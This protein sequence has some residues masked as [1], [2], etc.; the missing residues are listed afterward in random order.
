MNALL[1][2][3]LPMLFGLL[4]KSTLLLLA[5]AVA[6]LLLRRASAAVRH[7]V[8]TAALGG[9]LLLPILSLSLPRWHVAWGR[10][11]A[12]PISAVSAPSAGVTPAGADEVNS[13]SPMPVPTQA[14]D[15]V[16]TPS[17]PALAT[18][19]TRPYSVPDLCALALLAIWLAGF[20]L[21]LG[22]FF[23]GMRRIGRIQKRTVALDGATLAAAEDARQRL[24]VRP[25]AFLRATE[26]I[27]AVPITWGVFR[28]VVLLP[29]SSASWSGECLRAA[30]LHELAHVQ[31]GDWAT[32]VAARFACAL[33]WW[34]PLA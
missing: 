28:P 1:S 30:L 20:L 24:G 13:L 26:S 10:S 19:A 2:H 34:H 6:C 9:V 7:L 14:M 27:I 8:W 17:A 29:E 25:V 18:Q 32:Q 3:T 33:Y 11:V 12:S 5:T 15:G 21:V 16:R 31:R 23:I 22:Q 4:V